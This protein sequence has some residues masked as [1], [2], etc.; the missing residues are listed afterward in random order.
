[1]EVKD[2]V[3]VKIIRIEDGKVGLLSPRSCPPWWRPALDSPVLPRSTLR[4][5][6][7]SMKVVDQE[8]GHDL[9]PGNTQVC[10]CARVCGMAWCSVW[11]WMCVLWQREPFSHARV[12]RAILWWCHGPL[13]PRCEPCVAVEVRSPASPRL[14][15][16]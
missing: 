3:W 13:H 1:M 16:C 6:S 14:M 10:W 12:P 8:S 9:D 15:Q 4:Q 11:L 2:A 7:A 5:V